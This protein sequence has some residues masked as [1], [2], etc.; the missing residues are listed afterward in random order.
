MGPILGPLGPIGGLGLERPPL[1]G[2]ILKPYDV[3]GP[4][5]YPEVDDSYV[6]HSRGN[7]KNKAVQKRN[8]EQDEKRTQQ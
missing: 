5:R 6:A 1:R 4:G 2:A 7:H 3:R 8:Q